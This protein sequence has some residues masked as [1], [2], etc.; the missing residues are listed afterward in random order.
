MPSFICLSLLVMAFILWT[1]ALVLGLVYE[2]KEEDVKKIK[3]TTIKK[4]KS[5]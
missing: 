5:K 1:S 2:T 3:S 4:K